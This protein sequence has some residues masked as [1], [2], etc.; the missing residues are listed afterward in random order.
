ML[1]KEESEMECDNE[2][3]DQEMLDQISSD[4]KSPTPSINESPISR[5]SD[6]RKIV[7]SDSSESE[8]PSFGKRKIVISDSSDSEEPPKVSKF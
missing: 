7:I 6:K 2:E 5:R 3:N 4:N 8:E 1:K